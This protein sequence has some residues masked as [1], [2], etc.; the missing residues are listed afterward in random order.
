[1]S[2]N[3]PMMEWT[4]E[5]TSRF[6]DW[7]SQFPENYFTYQFG[8]TIVASLR[9]FLRGRDRVLDYGCGVGYLL[10]HL[11]REVREVYGADPSPQ[12]VDRT[13]ERFAALPNFRGAS[14]IEDLHR[15]VM[16]FDAIICI[17]VVEHLS[18]DVLKDVLTDVR[19]LLGPGGVA[20]FSTPNN[21][22]LSKNMMF[23]PATGETY[24][25]W[26]HLRSWD[27]NSLPAKLR[28][29]GY[30]VVDV[31]ETNMSVSRSMSPKSVLKRAIKRVLFG[32]PGRPHLVCV[33]KPA[34]SQG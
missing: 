2:R 23:C 30:E 26:Q 1:M 14:L 17:E 16:K 27:R 3:Y 7:H 10:P 33:A 6:W 28:S 29:S 21:E 32:D 8:A 13:N 4:D 9:Q 34:T 19:S 25:R 20:I 24:H 11:C 22:D 5:R 31:I 12:S 18:D 15:R